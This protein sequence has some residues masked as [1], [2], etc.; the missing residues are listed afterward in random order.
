MN[1]IND[2]ISRIEDARATNKSPCKNYATEAA[3]D[4]A[5]KKIAEL[6][7][8]YHGTRP[9]NYIVIYNEAWGRW[10]GAIDLNELISRKDAIGGYLG[11]AA[12]KGFFCY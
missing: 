12:N 9:A 4:K 8:Q 11:L 1:V 5:T 6:V 3:A 7:G 2:V 10:V